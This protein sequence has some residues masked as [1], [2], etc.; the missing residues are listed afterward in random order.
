M[1]I[2]AGE[3]FEN[4]AI[5]SFFQ[6]FEKD[7]SDD[8][9]TRCKMHDIVHDFVR[10]MITNEFIAIDGDKELDIDYKSVHHLRLKLAKEM[11]FPVSIYHAKNIH[12]LFLLFD[13]IDYNFN[14][15]ISN[16][17]QNFRCLRTLILDC[18]I[19]KILDVVE[20]FIHLR[21]LLLSTKVEIEE[22]PTTICNLCNL[23]TLHI[24][25]CYRLKKLPQYM[26]NLINLRH[27]I[28]YTYAMTQ[29]SRGIGRLISLRTLSHFIISGKDDKEGCKLG[30]LKN[31]NQL[32]GTLRIQWLGNVVDVCED[33][34]AQLKKKTHLRGLYLGFEGEDEN[35]RRINNNVLVLNDLEPH[36]D[37][38][39][40]E[41][42]DYQGTTL[43]PN[44]MMSLTKLKTFRLFACPELKGLPPLGKL[45]FL[46]SLSIIDLDSLENVGVEFL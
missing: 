6:D 19:K 44:W 11:L 41:I 42:Y 27:L 45:P 10:S 14:M 36:P 31:L 37:L 22:L 32:Q 18:P 40:L 29:F 35:D 4:L 16:L 17:F 46:E 26:S 12:T 15:L 3:Y 13:E 9:I 24:D 20:N 8:K 43:Y 39:Y 34:H 33:K 5:H 28:F 38:E 23:Q 30:E 2:L 1:E 25:N 21:F 7:A